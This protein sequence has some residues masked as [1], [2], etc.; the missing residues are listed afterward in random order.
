MIR[1]E[2]I[3]KIKNKFPRDFPKIFCDFSW[4]IFI[5]AFFIFCRQK[6]LWKYLRAFGKDSKSEIHFYAI[7]FCTLDNFA[8]ANV[9]KHRCSVQIVRNICTLDKLTK[10]SVD[11]SF[12][13]LFTFVLPTNVRSN[14]QLHQLPNLLFCPEP[15]YAK[16]YFP[17]CEQSNWFEN[18]YFLPRWWSNSRR[19]WWLIL[20]WRYILPNLAVLR[21]PTTDYRRLRQIW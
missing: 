8:A 6:F 19:W 13:F 9:T 11:E 5:Y 14:E 15:T 16:L 3:T 7:L 20:F 17:K 10:M 4:K 2:K 12:L 1:V 21:F 18:Y